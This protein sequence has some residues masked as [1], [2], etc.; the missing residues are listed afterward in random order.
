MIY[1]FIT[2][3]KCLATILITNSHYGNIWPISSMAMGGLLGNTLFFAASGF[4][5]FEIK[6]PFVEWYKKRIKR[7]Y[8]ILWIT[9]IIGIVIG[10]YYINS[11]KDF[12]GLFLYPTYYHFIQSI[13]IL[14]IVYYA[15]ICFKE[16]MK[17]E[18]KTLMIIVFIAYILI[19]ALSYDKSYYHID[20]VEE[21]MVRFLYLESMLLGA[22][23]REKKQPEKVSILKTYKELGKVFV[24]FGTYIVSK[25]MFSFQ[26]SI[27]KL[28]IINPILLFLTVLSIFDLLYRW[29]YSK[30]DTLETYRIGKYMKYLSGITLEI[31]LVQY[32]VIK[33]IPTLI[34]PM[35]LIVVTAGIVLLAA[36]VHMIERK[37]VE[38]SKLFSRSR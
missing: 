6:Q 23:Y 5:L 9:N 34:F 20:V 26:E 7:I 2:I 19:Y 30:M 22:H 32:F 24:C 28:Q 4:C 27:S 25:L 8:P 35:N 13:M 15:L 11:F 33:C 18:I 10:F 16:K 36:F 1:E 37:L 17:I 21:P 31:Y 12:F 29:E 14:Y 38:I 3:I